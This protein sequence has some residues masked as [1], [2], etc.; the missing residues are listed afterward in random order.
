MKLTGGLLALML[1]AGQA[2]ADRTPSVRSQG[3]RYHG[4]RTDITVPF[5]TSGPSAFVTTPLDQRKSEE[6]ADVI[7]TPQNNFGAYR[8]SPRIYSSPLADDLTKPSAR[9]VYNIPFYGARMGYGR[10]FNGYIPKPFLLP[11]DAK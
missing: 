7:L 6:V 9:P 8:V 5:L 11:S 4:T 1:L 3:Q 2:L 10:D